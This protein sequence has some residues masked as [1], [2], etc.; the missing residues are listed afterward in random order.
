MCAGVPL[1]SVAFGRK[2]AKKS[3]SMVISENVGTRVR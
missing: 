2:D 3:T 1:Y